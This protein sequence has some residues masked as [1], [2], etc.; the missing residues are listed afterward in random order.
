MTRLEAYDE[1]NKKK[2]NA[3]YNGRLFFSISSQCV[4]FNVC[5]KTFNVV[6]RKCISMFAY[7]LHVLRKSTVQNADVCH[8]YWKMR[9]VLTV[10]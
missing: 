6:N 5:D 8:A 1:N 4:A 9:N 2:N 10:C 3:G 7:S